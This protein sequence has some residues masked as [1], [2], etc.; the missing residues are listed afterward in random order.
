MDA[1]I[2]RFGE[3]AISPAERRLSRGS[4]PIPL[5]PQLF[6]ALLL[7]V[8]KPGT[9]VSKAEFMRA[10]WPDV[11]VAETNLTN[12]IVQL[13]KLL[14]RGT[15]DTV[16][17]FGYRLTLPVTGEPGIST[18]L[19]ERFVRGRELMDDRSL[20]SIIQ[21]RDLFTICVAEDPLFAPGWAWLGRAA[22]VLEKFRDQ[23]SHGLEVAEAAFRRAFAIDPDLASAHSFYTPLQVDTG[24]ASDALARLAGRTRRVGEDPETL[25]GLV[26]VLRCCGLLEYSVAAHQ[27][28]KQLDPTIR[29]SVAHSFF[30]LGDYPGVFASYLSHGYYLDAAS[31]AALGQTDRALSMLRSRLEQPGLGEF[32]SAMMMSLVAALEGRAE[33]TVV[34]A[35][36]A[37]RA[38]DPEGVFYFARHAGI[39]GD[40]TGALALIR[41][42]R[43]S[44][45]W[46]SY[47]L[48]HDVAF[49]TIRHCP[50]FTAE[51]ATARALE[52][53]AAREFFLAMETSPDVFLHGA[54]A[55]DRRIS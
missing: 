26:Q 13:R 22:R 9:L 25:T 11:H 7:L 43:E 12:I 35:Q 23:R 42:A 1:S 28:A 53:T 44:G 19:Y 8:R 3:F 45:F 33:D 6:D 39:C 17:K 52:N 38:P 5:S 24:K 20:P 16:S 48:G 34:L 46:C 18:K 47:A 27:R 37:A 15:I 29:T 50:G 55:P 21:A 32:M 30:L 10:L 41:Q 2:Y 4:D 51:L 54:G 40:G 49:S 31:W 14:G 36:K